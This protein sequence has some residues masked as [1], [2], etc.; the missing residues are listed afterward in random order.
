MRAGRFPHPART[1]V[2]PVGSVAGLLSCSPAAGVVRAAGGGVSA[3][4]A[5]FPQSGTGTGGMAAASGGHI[6][7]RRWLVLWPKFHCKA[8][9]EYS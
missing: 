7:F 5:G 3:E 6:I 4:R 8:N 9:R 2:P 1:A